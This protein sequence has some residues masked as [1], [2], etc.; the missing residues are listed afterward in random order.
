MAAV[1]AVVVFTGGTA[2]PAVAGAL[3]AVGTTAG[4]AA[5][6]I[7]GAIGIAGKAKSN[8]DSGKVSDMSSYMLTGARENL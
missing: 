1:V 5:G 4:A 2:I 6:M 8:Y 3:A 7:M